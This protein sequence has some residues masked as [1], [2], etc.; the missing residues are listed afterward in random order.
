MLGKT[1]MP[2]KAVVGEE[3]ADER[4]VVALVKLWQEVG[5]H[6]WV[7]VDRDVQIDACFENGPEERIVVVAAG[8]GIV[9]KGADKAM[10][11]D[12]SVELLMALLWL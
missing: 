4:V 11:L 6:G 5:L 10:H 7:K 1:H 9:E 3:G 2:P 12:T 8:S